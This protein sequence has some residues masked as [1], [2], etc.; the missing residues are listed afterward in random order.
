MYILAAVRLMEYSS[1]VFL[2]F[3]AY[4]L[5]TFF[6]ILRM[7]CSDGGLDGGSCLNK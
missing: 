4:Y 7:W 2:D 5:A 3:F 6:L 1:L